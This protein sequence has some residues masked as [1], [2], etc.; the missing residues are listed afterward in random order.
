M[1]YISNSDD[2]VRSYHEKHD[3]LERFIFP[4]DAEV[5]SGIPEDFRAARAEFKLRPL[6]FIEHIRKF[7]ELLETRDLCKLLFEHLGKST[8]EDVRCSKLQSWI[9]L[10]V[11][12]LGVMQSAKFSSTT[13]TTHAYD[14]E[15]SKRIVL[16]LQQLPES[17]GGDSY[18]SA[19]GQLR[20]FLKRTID[21]KAL[22]KEYMSK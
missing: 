20:K 19:A 5:S 6:E 21:H 2:G 4:V 17:S 18:S 3:W 12:I 13:T 11:A 10:Q 15:S 8:D 9:S 1:T 16:L 14:S 22:E 7:S